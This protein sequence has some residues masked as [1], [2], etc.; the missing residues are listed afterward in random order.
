LNGKWKQYFL[1]GNIKL[2]GTY[3]QGKRDGSQQYYHPNGKIYSSG[4][5]QND[6]KVGKW[7]Y[8]NAEGIID[9]TINYNE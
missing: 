9:T 4:L 2:E 7:I 1:N 5:Y 8:N 3:R 6:I